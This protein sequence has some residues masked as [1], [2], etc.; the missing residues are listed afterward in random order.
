VGPLGRLLTIAA[1]SVT[2]AALAQTPAPSARD[3]L[4][5]ARPLS[6]AQIAGILAASRQALAGKAYRWSTELDDERGRAGATEVVM[7]SNGRPQ[8]IRIRM[9]YEAGIVWGS[10]GSGEQ[11]SRRWQ[12][13]AV[14]VTEFTGRPAR[15][16]GATPA[17]GE[18]IVEYRNEGTGWT[19]SANTR[20][21]PGYPSGVFDILAG[22][23]S[24]ESGD[25]QQIG[26]RTARAFV[27]PWTPPPAAAQLEI[28]TGDPLPNVRRDP[29]AG[30]AGLRVLWIDAESLL[31]LRWESMYAATSPAAAPK[32]YIAYSFRYDPALTIDRPDGIAPPDCVR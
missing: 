12:V 18:L 32:P 1:C 7:A 11:T 31:P 26:D 16:C 2:T 19:A 15:A 17:A 25:V 5:A 27:A 20:P 9:T 28:V 23:L 30:T 8:F 14:T 13:N 4:A 21:Y 29:V 22:V 6:R 24:V 3:L 10:A